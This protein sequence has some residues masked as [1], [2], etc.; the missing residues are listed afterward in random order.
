LLEIANPNLKLAAILHFS[1]LIGRKQAN[2][3]DYDLRGDG[4]WTAA[5]RMPEIAAI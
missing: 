4:A 3:T 1:L 5:R 2:R